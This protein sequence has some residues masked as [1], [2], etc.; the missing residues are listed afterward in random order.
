MCQLIQVKQK[1]TLAGQNQRNVTVDLGGMQDLSFSINH[2]S[3]HSQ[4]GV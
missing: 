1:Q 2:G 3:Q 4:Q